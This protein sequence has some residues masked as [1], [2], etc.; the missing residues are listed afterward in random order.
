MFHI[1]ERDFVETLSGMLDGQCRGNGCG[2]RN[3]RVPSYDGCPKKASED[4]SVSAVLFVVGP[5]AFD[6]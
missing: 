4:L 5:K 2:E 3:I 1:R 6:H